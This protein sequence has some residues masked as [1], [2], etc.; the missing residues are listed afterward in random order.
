MLLPVDFDL[1]TSTNKHQMP[2]QNRR[3]PRS[4]P[5]ASS[6]QALARTPSPMYSSREQRSDF[7]YIHGAKNSS[8]LGQISTSSGAAR[9]GSL[10]VPAIGFVN[11]QQEHP[12]RDAPPSSSPP[13]TPNLFL[14]RDPY[15]RSD[16][17]STRSTRTAYARGPY[18]SFNNPLSGRPANHHE[19]SA[20]SGGSS[21]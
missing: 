9:S 18:L 21:S 12:G 8:H 3:N 16:R 15:P 19:S 11:S 2:S 5:R 20:E 14:N 1:Q 17:P 10:E 6:P 7:S 13:P 4:S